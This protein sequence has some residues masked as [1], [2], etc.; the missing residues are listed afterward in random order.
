MKGIVTE[1]DSPREFPFGERKS[2]LFKEHAPE[3]SR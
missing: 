3:L 2:D 1:Y